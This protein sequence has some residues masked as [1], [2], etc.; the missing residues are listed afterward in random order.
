MN[1]MLTAFHLVRHFELLEKERQPYREV[2]PETGPSLGIRL[3]R[4]LRAI[5]RR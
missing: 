3:F 1:D 4:R 5:R 2:V